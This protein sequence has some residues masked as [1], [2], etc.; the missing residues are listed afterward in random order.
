[1]P[2]L[3]KKY[4]QSSLFK[5]YLLMRRSFT[6]AFGNF[7]AWIFCSISPPLGPICEKIH[8][9][10]SWKSTTK[11]IL[12]LLILI[13]LYHSIT[14]LS[15]QWCTKGEKDFSSSSMSS[16]LIF[17]RQCSNT[18]FKALEFLFLRHKDHI[19]AGRSAGKQFLLLSMI[20][21]IS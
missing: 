15:S 9:A 1:M 18:T 10:Q 16:L 21:C 7:L 5:T 13:S 17:Q 3:T 4:S 19:T 8:N 12:I 6:L 20:L 2:K 14:P 11:L